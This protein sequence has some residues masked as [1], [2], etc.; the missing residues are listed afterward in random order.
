MQGTFEV[1][2][3]I[4]TELLTVI[5]LDDGEYKSGRTVVKNGFKINNEN[6]GKW[7][8]GPSSFS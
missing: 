7:Y 4:P 5:N 8:D 6:K 2:G 3:Q 1:K